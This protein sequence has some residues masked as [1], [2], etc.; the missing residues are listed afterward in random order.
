MMPA[1]FEYAR[2]ASV[3]E[4]IALLHKHGADAKLLAGGH[5][6]V[7]MMKLRLAR[8]SVLVD[9]GRVR[10]LAG[11]KHE[12]GRFTIGA[13][14]THAALAASKELEKHAPALWDAANQL[15][16][17]QVRNRGTIGGAC[18]HG[19]PSAD[20]PAVMLALDA[21]VHVEGQKGKK[22]LPADEFFVGM[23]ETKLRH[24]EILTAISFAD[25][26]ASA[27][28]KFHHPASHFAMVGVAANVEV[29]NGAISSVRLAVTGVGDAAFRA[30]AA[31][32]AL[33]GLKAGDE[34]AVRRALS[35]IVGKVEVRGDA[36]ASADYRKAMTDV[37]AA[38]AVH[39]ALARS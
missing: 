1:S 9:I 17:P 10:E 20:Y 30:T 31:E 11:I 23:F 12:G 19:D 22:E 14:T 33:A 8:P 38:R 21:R 37:F 36:F 25:A 26:H 32:K 28:A 16:D 7:P 29:K 39:A 27:Y 35:G 3:A 15:G 2:A 34:A 6:L 5:S 13:L 18:A 24:G 4:A